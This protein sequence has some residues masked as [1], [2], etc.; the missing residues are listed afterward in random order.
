MVMLLN[1]SVQLSTYCSFLK[2][3]IA[4]EVSSNFLCHFLRF[5]PFIGFNSHTVCFAVSHFQWQKDISLLC[6]R[7]DVRLTMGEWQVLLP[8]GF[9]DTWNY[10]Y[11]SCTAELKLVINYAEK[12][13]NSVFLSSIANFYS[14]LY[15]CDFPDLYVPVKL[16]SWKVIFTFYAHSM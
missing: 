16:C 2:N 8:D 9:P 1:K 12:N 3:W 10:S 7:H 13:G 5:L 11:I 15:T 6:S 4:M 14:V